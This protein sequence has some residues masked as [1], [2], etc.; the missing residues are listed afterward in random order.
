MT[1]KQAKA[2]KEEYLGI[3]RDFEINNRLRIYRAITH[4]KSQNKE[5]KYAEFLTGAFLEL[6]RIFNEKEWKFPIE[7]FLNE[8]IFFIGRQNSEIEFNTYIDENGLEIF[9]LN[10][11]D[12]SKSGIITVTEEEITSFATVM[13]LFRVVIEA[14][15]NALNNGTLEI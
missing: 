5:N 10:K 15:R 1:T 7:I 6:T 14:R 3:L 4:L 12:F 2:L 8:G 11:A 9:V 13:L